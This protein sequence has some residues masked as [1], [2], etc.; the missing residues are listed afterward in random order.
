MTGGA[1]NREK[2]NSH[3]PHHRRLTPKYHHHRHHPR[4]RQYQNRLT[5]EM[6]PK[7]STTKKDIDANNDQDTQHKIWEPTANFARTKN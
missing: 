5:R 3:Y 1:P 2:H 4:M 7:E 6:K